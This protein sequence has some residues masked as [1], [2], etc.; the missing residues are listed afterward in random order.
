MIRPCPFTDENPRIDESAYVDASA[1]VL[2]RVT[3]GARSSIW[4]GT[5]VRGD[6][7]TISIGEETNVQDLSCIHV[8]KDRFSTTLG[9]RVSVGH[10]VVLHGCTVGDYTL[11]GMRATVMDEVTIGEECLIAAGALLTPG[12]V[13][14]PRSLVMGSPAK[15]KREVDAKELELLH[16]TWKNYVDYSRRYIEKFGRG[17]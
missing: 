7:H 1:L 10:G 11:V 6:V 12:L 17:F 15:V 9:N 14:P 16:R 4:P 8:L 13:V 2:G 5:V 3:I